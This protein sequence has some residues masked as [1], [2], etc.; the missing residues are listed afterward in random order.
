MRRKFSENIEK[1][2]E[3]KK[4]RDELWDENLASIKRY[5]ERLREVGKIKEERFVRYWSVVLPPYV[6]DDGYVYI[7]VQYDIQGDGRIKNEIIK[8]DDID[9]FLN[10]EHTERRFKIADELFN[11][12]QQRDI[13]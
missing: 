13:W 8:V 4:Q 1:R 5:Y 11:D 12:N 7:H 6:P 10:Y 9:N 3:L 2:S